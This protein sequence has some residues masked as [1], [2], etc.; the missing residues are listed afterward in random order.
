MTP[1]PLKW[2]R[3]D[4]G[5]CS[6]EWVTAY[7]SCWWGRLAGKVCVCVCVSQVRTADSALVPSLLSCM[8][9]SCRDLKEASQLLP[10]EIIVH[11]SFKYIVSWFC[12]NDFVYCFSLILFFSVDIF[13]F[14]VSF[15][16]Q[17]NLIF[18]FKGRIH[19]NNCISWWF[20]A[21]SNATSHLM[22]L[23]TLYASSESCDSWMVAGNY[24]LTCSA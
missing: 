2:H 1:V 7:R 22:W 8:P 17:F 9:I 13:L 19:F 24:P 16:I 15:L 10:A 11:C 3:P 18:I 20:P 23:F 4:R 14:V 5:H 6:G 12:M 21:E